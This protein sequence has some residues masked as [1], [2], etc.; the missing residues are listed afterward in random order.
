MGFL[1]DYLRTQHFCRVSEGSQLSRSGV[2]TLFM[3]WAEKM[4]LKLG[5]HKNV[6]KKTW[7]AKFILIKT[8]N[9]D[10]LTLNIPLS[11]ITANAA[12]TMKDLLLIYKKICLKN[13]A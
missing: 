13:R 5:G 7:R 12:N 9:R 4:P 3:W 6:S 8:N 11:T 2:A 1:H 10:S